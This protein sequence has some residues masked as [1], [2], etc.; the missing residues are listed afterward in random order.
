YLLND[1]GHINKRNNNFNDIAEKKHRGG[2]GDR[3]YDDG[4]GSSNDSLL[5]G[6]HDGI[7]LNCLAFTSRS[8]YTTLACLNKRFISL[9]YSGY[10]YSLPLQMGILEHW[11][12]LVC[13]LRGWEAFDPKRQR[14]SRFPRIPCDE[15]FH[16]AEK[17]SLAVSTEIP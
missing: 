1:H 4:H 9:I 6:L 8:D 2:C 16:F 12:Y 13:D 5:P 15:C 11:V 17:E 7:A 3:D 10:L 14:W